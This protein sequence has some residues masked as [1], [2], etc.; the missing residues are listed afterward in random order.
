LFAEAEF[1]TIYP[2]L[3]KSIKTI[4]KKLKAAITKHFQCYNKN[5]STTSPAGPADHYPDP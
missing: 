3:G 4:Q 5:L 2:Y 1:A